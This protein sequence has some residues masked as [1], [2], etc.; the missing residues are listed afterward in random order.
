MSDHSHLTHPLL[1]VLQQGARLIERLPPGLYAQAPVPLSNAGVGE[2]LR[3]CLDFVRA[4]VEGLPKQRIDY[5]SRQRDPAI[6]EDPE[7]A[8]EALSGLCDRIASLSTAQL[9]FE[10]EVR[11]RQDAPADVPEEFSWVRSSV[12]REFGLVMSHTVHHYALIAMTLRHFDVDPG[13]EFGVAPSTLA[14]W[15]QEG[16]C[17]PLVG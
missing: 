10:R 16:R 4:L 8:L 14:Y 11:V 2:H 5:D 6:E 3:H 7:V 1:H 13:A 9:D 15:R 12:G 17:A